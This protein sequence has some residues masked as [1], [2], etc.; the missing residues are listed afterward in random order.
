[1]DKLWFQTYFVSGLIYQIVGASSHNAAAITLR[2][3]HPP[4]QLAFI[5]LQRRMG[6]VH[7][8]GT[9][10]RYH[11]RRFHRW[12]SSSSS[13]SSI[14]DDSTFAI[15]TYKKTSIN[16]DDET[17]IDDE[18][19]NYNSSSSNNNG[20]M[21]LDQETYLQAEE[22]LLRSDGSLDLYASE[23]H[24]QQRVNYPPPLEVIPKIKNK[25]YKAAVEGLFSQP[26]SY[27]YSDN[28][29]E[30]A[31]NNTKLS[32]SKQQLSDEEQLYQAVMNIENGKRDVSKKQQLVDPEVLHQQVFAE[33]QTYLQ[34]STEFRKSLS[35]LYNN[36]DNTESPMAKERRKAIEKYNEE[37]LNELMKEMDAMEEM[38]LSKEDALRLAKEKGVDESNYQPNTGTGKDGIVCSKCGLRVTPD[39]VQRAEII[40]RTKEGGLEKKKSIIG[41]GLLCQACYGQQFRTVD[42]SKVRVATSGNFYKSPYRSFDTNGKKN[43]QQSWKAKGDNGERYRRM[44]KLS[45]STGR[46]DVQGVDTSSLFDLPKEKRFTNDAVSAPISPPQASAPSLPKTEQQRN[47]TRP[48]R[49]TT[50]TLGGAAELAKRRMLQHQ[51]LEPTSTNSENQDEIERTTYQSIQTDETVPSASK[52]ERTMYSGERQVEVHNETYPSDGGDR[53]MKVEDPGSKKTLYWNTETGEMKK[54]LEDSY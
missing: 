11:Q 4:N 14:L 35:S 41:S 42:E 50:R 23:Q 5:L 26:P 25:T 6:V 31:E 37:V 13:S 3:Y 52:V 18:S 20:G 8:N 17:A 33:E 53:W 48:P 46:S 34:Q 29:D 32:K 47:R 12:P 38:A 28:N 30:D 39:M 22:N 44:R 51:D 54:R 19:S 21:Y 10:Q 2:D 15:R 9:R 49:G 27:S 16:D 1:M 7:H 45:K 24:Q 43:T 40:E 36:D